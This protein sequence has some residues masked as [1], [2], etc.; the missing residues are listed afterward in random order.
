MEHTENTG[1]T[2]TVAE[3]NEGAEPNT[4]NNEGAEPNTENNEGAEPNTENNEGAEPTETCNAE[5]TEE[6][7]DILA[8]RSILERIHR[9]DEY[10]VFRLL[11]NDL[12]VDLLIDIKKLQRILS[13]D[14]LKELYES[15]HLPSPN[16]L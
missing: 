2:E 4:E 15:S 16:F 5:N 8:Y 13:D 7:L 10:M 6:Q 1:G 11:L 3:N 12:L 9:H 14:A